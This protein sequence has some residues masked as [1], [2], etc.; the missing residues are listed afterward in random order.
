[1]ASRAVPF[2]RI[3]DVT[4]KVSWAA[5]GVL[6]DDPEEAAGEAAEGVAEEARVVPADAAPA[7]AVGVPTAFA[8]LEPAAAERGAEPPHAA[9]PIRATPASPVTTRC[10]RV[11]RP[12][13][14]AVVRMGLPL[15]LPPAVRRASRPR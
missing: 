10:R 11:V 15:A 3:A 14:P 5:L 1:M 6:A 13:A 9:S 12:D 8:E 7:A 4:A 2:A